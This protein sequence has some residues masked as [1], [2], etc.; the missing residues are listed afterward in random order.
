MQAEPSLAG[1]LR[2]WGAWRGGRVRT[3]RCFLLTED[4]AL[5]QAPEWAPTQG[6]QGSVT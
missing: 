3:E 6:A 5:T 2:S 4:R 1:L